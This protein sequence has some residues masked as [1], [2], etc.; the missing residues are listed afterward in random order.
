MVD[1]IEPARADESEARLRAI[2]ENTPDLIWSVDAQDFRLLFWN[3]AFA[4]F[5]KTEYKAELRKGMFCGEI[6][7]KVLVQRWSGYFERV[8]REGPFDNKYA[9]ASGRRVFQMGFNLV[10]IKDKVNAI[11]VFARDV[12]VQTRAQEKLEQ[13]RIEIAR[14]QRVSTIGQLTS[15]IT[16]QLGQ[17]LTAIVANARAAARILRADPPPVQEIREILED[18]LADNRRAGDVIRRLAALASPQKAIISSLDLNDIVIQACELLRSESAIRGVRVERKLTDALPLVRGDAVQITQVLLNILL[19]GLEAAQITPRED[20]WLVIRTSL[21][22]DFSVQITISDN[23][24][25][26]PM[27]KLNRLF[28]PFYTTKA[29]GLGMGLSI[30]K[31]IVERYKGSLR[32][33]NAPEGGAVF[34]IT[35]PREHASDQPSLN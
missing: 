18:I 3:S 21:T 32:A 25:G 6:L 1:V 29:D 16:H 24:P 31:A 23:G 20:K 14:I 8:L 35:L 19:N 26:L 2:L 33:E 27:Q 12:T 22:H 10:R 11:S 34:H 7:P 4:K 28:E 17:P 15:S 9:I 13:N 30:A 5:A